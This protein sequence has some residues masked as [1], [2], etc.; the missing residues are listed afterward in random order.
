MKK[1]IAILA[2]M[3]VAIISYSQPKLPD[4]VKPAADAVLTA[5]QYVYLGGTS[6]DTLTNG[7][8][9]TYT[10]RIFG[11]QTFDVRAQVYIDHISGTAAYKVYTYNSMDGT[12]WSAK[13]GDSLTI[14]GI[15]ADQMYPTVM[16]FSDVMWPYKKIQVIQTGTAKTKPKGYIVTR[17]N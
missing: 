17:N 13:T 16:N 10:L 11:G 7:D 8:T 4:V 12:N 14:T 15:T 2:L 1:L 9:L 5:G 3:V 6:A